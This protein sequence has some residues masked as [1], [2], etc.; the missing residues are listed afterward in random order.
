AAIVFLPLFMVNVV[1]LSATLAGLTTTPLTFGIVAGNVASGQI[2]ARTGRYKPTMLGALALLIGAFA[3]MGFTLSPTSTQG[4]VT[5]KMAAVGIG[6]GPSIPLYTLA[7]QNSVTPDRTGV[8]TASATFFRAMGS[9]I[10]VTVM[11]T[12]FAGALATNLRT[13]LALALQEAPPVLR[14]VLTEANALP[15]AGAEGPASARLG[16]DAEGARRALDEHFARRA[17]SGSGRAAAGVPDVA[18][19]SADEVDRARRAAYAAVARVDHAAK[20]ALTNAIERIYQLCILV[21]LVAL[22]FTRA[23]PELPLKR[24][25]PPPALASE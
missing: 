6:L 7:I 17:R 4:E 1:G 25:P 15:A 16:F 14:A 19:A 21:A 3:V 10:G 20:S 13:E 2:V 22:L 23:L 18:A 5:L 11:G 24:R 12:V 9:T 8:A